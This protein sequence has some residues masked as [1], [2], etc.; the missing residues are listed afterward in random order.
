MGFLPVEICCAKRRR[1]FDK[2]N[3]PVPLF[4]KIFIR[5]DLKIRRRLAVM[6][7]RIFRNYVTFYK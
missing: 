3:Q 4:F 7:I 1:F 5:G 2:I 6:L